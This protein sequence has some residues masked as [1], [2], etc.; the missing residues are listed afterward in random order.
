M[1]KRKKAQE[2]GEKW[3]HLGPTPIHWQTFKSWVAPGELTT[4][5]S[6]TTKIHTHCNY[7]HTSLQHYQNIERKF[8]WLFGY[9][10]KL[11]HSDQINVR[12]SGPYSSPCYISILNNYLSHMIPASPSVSLLFRSLMTIHRYQALIQ[13]LLTIHRYSA[14][15]VLCLAFRS[16]QA[17]APVTGSPQ[18]GQPP[19]GGQFND[20]SRS[21]LNMTCCVNNV[22]KYITNHFFQLLGMHPKAG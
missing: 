19:T 16:K 8:S 17:P 10:I 4:L 14:F 15:S 12:Y 5:G 22:W 13:S 9:E 3:K 6:P 18:Q 1:E 21:P 20:L 11:S 2:K 7:M